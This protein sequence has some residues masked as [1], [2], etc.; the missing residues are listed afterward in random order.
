M[1]CSGNPNVKV[2]GEVKLN[3]VALENGTIRFE[4][5]DGNAPTAE[6]VISSGRYEVAM[7]PGPKKVSVQ[8]FKVVGKAPAGGPGGA[9]IDR[10]VQLIPDK[11]S[12]PAK[13]ELNAGY[14][15]GD[16]RRRF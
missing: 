12:D 16:R 15:S 2:G 11:Y 7:L 4:P 8:S 1:G 13:T 3:G 5:A 14:S 9:M 10:T 6:A